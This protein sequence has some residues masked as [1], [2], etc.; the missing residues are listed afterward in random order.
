MGK[1][2][3]RLFLKKYYLFRLIL[4][5]SGRWIE[6][7]DFRSKTKSCIYAVEKMP[8]RSQNFRLSNPIC[9]SRRK[10]KSFEAHRIS[11]HPTKHTITP[12]NSSDA[13]LT[14]TAAAAAAA[15]AA[16]SKSACPSAA[17]TVIRWQQCVLSMTFLQHRCCC[18]ARF[19]DSQRVPTPQSRRWKG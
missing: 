4:M 5:R 6:K 1:T 10:I 11:H 13:G 2:G 8:F 7:G 14:A 9:A 19:G 17:R 3:K 12:Y 16:H 18:C 15:A